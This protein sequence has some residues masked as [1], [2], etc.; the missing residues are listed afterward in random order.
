VI[1]KNWNLLQLTEPVL[2]ALTILFPAFQH[3]AGDIFIFNSFET[4]GIIRDN[5]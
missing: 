5:A 4:N 2:K 1:L 3:V